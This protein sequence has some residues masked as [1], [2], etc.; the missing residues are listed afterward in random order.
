MLVLGA[1]AAFAADPGRP[2]ITGVSHVA[3]YAADPSASER[4]Y[5]H[6]LGAVKAQD[7]ENARGVRYYF[8]STQY[9]EILP[10]PQGHPSINRLDHVAFATTNAD[11]LRAYL[12]AHAITVPRQVMRGGDGSEWFDE[13]PGR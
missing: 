13:G 10:L 6:D 1:T 3:L 8:S 12:A 9:V 7:A 4:F 2:P 11:G 5:V